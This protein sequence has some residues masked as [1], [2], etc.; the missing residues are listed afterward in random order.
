[1]RL[2]PGSATLTYPEFVTLE[3]PKHELRGGLLTANLVML[4]FELDPKLILR[5]V[6]C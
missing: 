4:N 2:A 1:M 6:P 5:R 3:P